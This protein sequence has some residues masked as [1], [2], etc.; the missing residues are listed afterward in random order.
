MYKNTLIL[1]YIDLKHDN[2]I[3]TKF[4]GLGDFI[5]YFY[6]LGGDR[7]SFDLNSMIGSQE[8]QKLSN[9]LFG[10]H[11][12]CGIVSV[13]EKNG[14]PSHSNLQKNIDALIKM[15]HR[16]GFINGEGD[17]SGVLT[18]IPR[19]LWA[20]KLHTNYQSSDLAYSPLFVIGHL[21]IENSVASMSET[22]QVIRE[23]FAKYQIEILVEEENQV[24]TNALGPNGKKQEPLFW[25]IAGISQS[26][27]TALKKELFSLA[28]EIE[29]NTQV[30]IASLSNY[31]AVYKVLGSADV[32]PEYYLDLNNPSFETTIS[33]G[34]N[35]YSTNTL[36]HFFRVQPFTLL[37]HNGEINTIQRLRD[38][39][40]MLN[41]PLVYKGSDSQDLNRVIHGLITN[42]DFSLF[43]TMEFIFP[44]IYNEIF[45]IDDKLKNLYTF[46]RHIWGPFS[47]GPAGIV[48]RFENHAL[49]SVDAMGL[50]PLWQVETDQT[51]Y[52]SSEQGIV[53]ATEMVSEPKPF[54]PG[55]KVGIIFSEDSPIQILKHH[56]L[57]QMVYNEVSGR[58]P[59]ENYHQK[60]E[61][62]HFRKTSSFYPSFPTLS[63]SIYRA[64]GWEKE[65]IDLA[66]QIASTGK[67]PIRSLGYDGPLAILSKER[68][69]IPDF[70][71]ET[72]AV[73]TN[74]AIDREREV[75]HF[76]TRMILGGR[77]DF[78]TH[79]VGDSSFE[80]RSPILLEGEF[81]QSIVEKL[82]TT[83]LEQTIAYFSSESDKYVVALSL[84]F[85]PEQTIEE[86]LEEL[87]NEAIIAV[88]NGAKIIILDDQ[89]LFQND[90]LLWLDP[91]LAI[92]S[93]D[94][95]LRNEFVS[96]D[97]L[98]RKV[99]LILRSG[100]VRHLHDIIT[101]IG[102]GADAI[103][104]YLLFATVS[105]KGDEELIKNLYDGLNK[106]IEKVIS[107]LGI[108]ELRGYERLFSSIGL[109][110]EIADLLN[111]INF[112]GSEE[113][114]YSFTQLEEDA[115]L[116]QKDLH[117]DK[118]KALRSFRL[119]P[120]VWKAISEVANGS[121]SYKE[122]EEKL[123]EEEDQNPIAI[124]HILDFKYT[125]KEVP[126]DEVTIAI[127]NHDYPFIISSMS[128]G[129]QNETSFRAYAEAAYQ[130][131]MMSLSG[132]GGEIKDMLGKYPNNRGM[133]IASGRFGVNVE[134][135]NSSNWIEIKIGQGA[136]PGEG[137]H[138]PGSKVSV[139][140]A[141]ARNATPG[142][143]L[144]SP[145][146]NHDIYSIED[147]AQ[148]VAELKTANRHS[149]VIIKVPVVPNIGTIA[150]GIAKAGADVVSL[151]GYDGGTGAARVHAIQHVGLP[152]EI[153]VKNT[154]QSLLE[155]GLRSDVE[156]W[157]D[158]G[159][160]SSRDVL[161]LILL[162]A[163][164][165]GFGTLAM[166]AIGC[167]SCRGCHLD[168]CHVGISTQIDSIEEANE[169]GL[170]RFV[171]RVYN[172]SV[173][174]LKRLFTIIGDEVRELTGKLGARSLQD[175]VG[176]ADFLHQTNYHQ[177][178]DLT[179]LLTSAPIKQ[180]LAADMSEKEQQ[181]SIAVG[182]NEE[183][184][185]Q[186]VIVNSL[187]NERLDSTYRMIGSDLSGDRVR[188]HLDGSYRSLPPIKLS[189]KKGSV[190]G[191]GLAAYLADG[192]RI[193]V[194]GGGQDGLG[195]TAYGGKVSIIKAKNKHGV[196]YNGSVGKGC[197][198]GAQSGLFIIQGNAD[199]RAGIRLSGADVIIGGEITSPI[200][201][202]LG[203]IGERANIKGFAFEYMTNGRAVVLGDPGPWICSGMTGGVIYQRLIP[204]YGIDVAAIRRRIAKGAKVSIVA[205]NEKGKSDLTELL[206]I[207][208]QELLKAN[209][210]ENAQRI[211]NL[212][213][214]LDK[215]FVQIIPENHVLE[216][217]VLTE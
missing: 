202:H 122:Y 92:S 55:E 190:P 193:D 11:D 19:K 72:V 195:K 127:D 47:Q 185:Q 44:P 192:V 111:I 100:A 145:S 159:V 209:Q 138:L 164:R 27:V 38:E 2:I 200:Q 114:G 162:G 50:R 74:P 9:L 79:T 137:G 68:V 140:V 191:N 187:T 139:K 26:T 78:N 208:T 148:I 1:L 31:S 151:S 135:I 199:S 196:Y 41:I 4:L 117:N 75:E 73:V 105:Q 69:N 94:I 123:L 46:A 214:D 171:P 88:Q 52:F 98:R 175:L 12:S 177:H 60:L 80:I 93:I 30:H 56:E 216:S 22:Q 48:S 130:L 17:G 217:T 13:I 67:E 10:E 170:K 113:I 91:H 37:G 20:D 180:S 201:D 136:K 3:L 132:E 35:R 5:D 104:P 215:N 153:G 197:C 160:R 211:M 150:V 15:N 106:G 96:N 77:E 6:I 172:P 149:K 133:Q 63:N 99:S 64:F 70:L 59:L 161:K 83:S 121:R 57:Q 53:S 66:E 146:N 173:E 16:S 65:H 21:F 169:R 103:S 102:L 39:S 25:Q 212:L 134:F 95:A 144:I 54:A 203:G 97:N 36:S 89:A 174:N 45:K 198:Y 86:R 115:R 165:I 124:R 101:A 110:E 7:V 43:S 204:D 176:R 206:N 178:L 156:V 40:K 28:I 189:L 141:A 58:F 184:I 42:Y 168:T 128:F 18:D 29:E 155:A 143:D 108:H 32:L 207:Y 119:L 126:K 163:N 181:F 87:K 71:K 49:F 120:R 118:T 147:L 14:R 76:S 51:L 24:D 33:I 109:S 182:A 129:S 158:G 8:K 213:N 85:S 167:T 81:S 34:H 157:A 179:S 84:A 154:H 152:I 82:G 188:E 23:K 205:L 183:N 90:N 107:T 61:P 131:N 186:N 210:K 125:N 194:Q 116:R 62:P 142:T 112:Y 166:I